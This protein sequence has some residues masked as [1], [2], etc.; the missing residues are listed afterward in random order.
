M[1][2]GR[3][4]LK[5]ISPVWPQ[6]GADGRVIVDKT[7]C[8]KWPNGGFV[9]VKNPLTSLLADLL[10]SRPEKQQR[11]SVSLTCCKILSHSWRGQFLL[12]V[13][14]PTMNCSLNVAMARLAALTRWLWGGPR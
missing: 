1:L 14:S 9:E 8:S 4:D 3:A 6:A 12:T 13:A 2:G 5:W 11:L 7:F 10:G